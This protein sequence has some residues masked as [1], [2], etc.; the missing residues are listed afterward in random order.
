MTR[1]I[2]NN[3]LTLGDALG[4]YLEEAV[5]VDIAVGYFNLR[6][7][8]TLAQPLS[9]KKIGS[10]PVARILIGMT[11]DERAA[12]RESVKIRDAAARQQQFGIDDLI[13]ENR[14]A[15]A[16]DGFREQLSSGAPS[17]RDYQTIRVLQEHISEGRLEIRLYTEKPLHGKAYILHTGKAM[18]PS[19]GFVGSSNLTLAGLTRNAELN[20]DV[21]D[22]HGNEKLSGWFED[23]W[24][25][26]WCVDISTELLELIEESWTAEIQLSPYEL[27]L[28]VCFHL[29]QDARDA[30]NL[31]E[32]PQ[33]FDEVLLDYQKQAVQI[34]ARR[35]DVKGGAIL[36]DVVGLGKT[37]TAVATAAM[38][39][40]SDSRYSTLIVC[41]PNLEKM[42]KGIMN[43]FKIHHEVVPYSQVKNKLPALTRFEFV[44]ADESHY[45]RNNG[46]QHYA[47]LAEYIQKNQSKIL[48][49]SATPLNT[50]FKDVANQLAMYIADD[51]DMG[52]EPEEALR[53]SPGSFNGMQGKLRTFA[54]FKRSKESAD[55]ARL[56]SDHLVRRTRS[57]IKKN[58]AQQENGRDFLTF[59]NGDKFFFPERTSIVK[60]H[61]FGA[62]DPALKMA[63]EDTVRAIE[64]LKLPRNDLFKYANQ[65]AF[66]DSKEDQDLLEGLGRARGNLMGITRTSFLKR[67]SSGG[68][69]F[70]LSIR[71]HLARNLAWIYAIDNGLDLPLGAVSTAT[72]DDF[73]DV[74]EDNADFEISED[75]PADAAAAR[76]YEILKTQPDSK[77]KWVRPELFD[78]KLR[79]DLAADAEILR[80]LLNEFG[81][82]TIATDSKLHALMELINVTHPKEKVLIFTEY[83]DTANYLGQAFKSLGVEKF[84]VV[85]SDSKDPTATA[86]RFAPVSNATPGTN[87]VEPTNP[88][89]ILIS[90]DVL[91]EGQNLQ[92][93]HIVVNYDLPWAIIKLVQRAGRVDRVGQKS[94]VVM[95][96]SFLHDEVEPVLKLRAAIK[97]RLANIAQAIG[98]DE[99][100]LGDEAERNI[101]EGLAEGRL[102][103]EDDDDVDGVSKAY[104]TW[105]NLEREQPDLAKRIASLP[106]LLYSTRNP[107]ADD[108]ADFVT[109]ARSEG[110]TNLFGIADFEAEEIEHFR[111]I[112]ESEALRLM[113]ADAG[114]ETVS[115]RPDHF[116]ATTWIAENLVTISRS[117]YGQLDWVR[118]QIVEKLGRAD[119][120]KT[121][122]ILGALRERPL[123]SQADGI[124]KR[125]LRTNKSS[126]SLELL[127][128]SLFDSDQL[129][130]PQKDYEEGLEIL[131]SLG[132]SK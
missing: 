74:D 75:S 51:A 71:R 100:F 123:T 129:L 107:R 87:P 19:V 18:T 109:F 35:I 25:S 79:A 98:N 30:S 14:K 4:E 58:F 69:P 90:T 52:I 62:T 5:S 78:S 47:A 104:Q 55:W 59:A 46:T 95:V 23:L 65:D 93:A 84:E 9:H 112:S 54:A 128:T 29:S 61:S 119:S 64:A 106:N 76:A 48:L 3:E 116:E 45:L 86:Q 1:I 115:R 89:R 32:L 66:T 120:Q 132:I 85:S 114:E 105:T 99:A 34:I 80:S 60:T 126:S 97:K 7:Y 110:R 113:K 37:L 102:P 77:R 28:K 127:L 67:L 56:L 21:T 53:N 39:Q 8:E 43:S 96:Y 121:Q 17:E 82:W 2:D 91:S 20:V 12:F 68:F 73:E 124:L 26:P 88:L 83:K 22:F 49:L 94:P 27:Y 125:A 44:I 33:E 101:I 38:L 108:K 13:L 70:V 118:R 40:S 36:G 117:G 50:K 41:P 63:S 92:D 111:A 72:L 24:T 6:G 81:E 31:Y 122:R 42:W 10:E 16:I 15:L 11:V 131:L 103:E 57:Y 130:L